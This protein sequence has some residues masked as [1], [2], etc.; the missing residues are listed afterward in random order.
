[1]TGEEWF[2]DG[3]KE[4]G[5]N[6]DHTSR[7]P[8]SPPSTTRD[9][10]AAA[11]EAA[12]LGGQIDDAEKIKLNQRSAVESCRVSYETT[13]WP[14]GKRSL[15]IERQRRTYGRNPWHITGDCERNAFWKS[16]QELRAA[17]R[18]RVT[19]AAAGEVRKARKKSV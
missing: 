19:M 9:S 3:T 16:I 6:I 4:T 11:A 5:A 10:A 18:T 12:A 8:G 14:G 1:M 17:H 13:V 7:E 2:V 15:V